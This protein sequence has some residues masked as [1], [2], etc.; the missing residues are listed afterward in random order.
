[1]G[2]Y[3]IMAIRAPNLDD[4]EV[5]HRLGRAYSLILSY[6]KAKTDEAAGHDQAGDMTHP[7]TGADASAKAVS[8]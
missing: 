2:E 5:R 8:S 7:A 6:R 1:M 3:E 4:Q